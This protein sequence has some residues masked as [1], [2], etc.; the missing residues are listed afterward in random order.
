[1]DKCIICGEWDFAFHECK[2]LYFFKHEDW[3][4]EWQEIRATSSYDAAIE[5]A[6]KYNEDDYTLMGNTISVKIKNPKGEVKTFSVSAE[7]DIL[8]T[9]NEE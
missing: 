5:F 9:A 4:D 2:A 1:M 8:Y 6:E 7:Q 3:G